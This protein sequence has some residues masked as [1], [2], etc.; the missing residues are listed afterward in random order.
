L[1]LEP[2]EPR[3]LLAAGGL[4]FKSL[5]ESVISGTPV[6]VTVQVL[7]AQGQPDPTSTDP[8]TIALASDPGGAALRGTVTANAVA[9]V[10]RFSD[11]VITTDVPTSGFSFIAVSGA[12]STEVSNPF[13]VNAGPYQL[14]FTTQTPSKVTAGAALGSV[15]VQLVDQ[16]GNPTTIPGNPHV[17]L[18]LNNNPTGAAIQGI[19]TT[20]LNAQGQAVFNNVSIDTSAQDTRWEQPSPRP[21][22]RS[23]GRRYPRHS[24]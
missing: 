22:K 18:Y 9:G 21:R 19:T 7:N 1:T 17:S 3:C 20:T 4:A 12:A 14:S 11:L 8:V 15:I 10:A 6:T 23:S 24:R 2:L 16:S 5:P 13:P